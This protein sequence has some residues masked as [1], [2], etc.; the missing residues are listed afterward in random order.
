MVVTAAHLQY[1]VSVDIL[2]VEF[3]V[4]GEAAEMEEGVVGG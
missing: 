3:E 1:A 4:A 2:R